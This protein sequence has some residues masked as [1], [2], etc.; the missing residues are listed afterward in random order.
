MVLVSLDIVA[1]V[2]DV[3]EGPAFYAL[4]PL[5]FSHLDVFK[6]LAL[7]LFGAAEVLKLLL[8]PFVCHLRFLN[9]QLPLPDVRPVNL[10]KEGMS[11]YLEGAFHSCS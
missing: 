10:G 2:V 3:H 4:G 6:D 9:L 1:L 11:L 7:L 8:E 5:V